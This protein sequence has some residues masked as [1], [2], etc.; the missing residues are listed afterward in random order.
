MP[1]SLVPPMIAQRSCHMAALPWLVFGAGLLAYVYSLATTIG[2]FGDPPYTANDHRQ[3]AALI[4][5]SVLFLFSILAA[6][7]TRRW[8]SAVLL[9]I[10]VAALSLLGWDILR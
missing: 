8:I 7:V 3:R 10:V 9:A 5:W 1:N 4:A 2:E 6:A